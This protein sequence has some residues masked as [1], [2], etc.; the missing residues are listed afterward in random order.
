MLTFRR[1]SALGCVLFQWPCGVE[2]DQEIHFQA[3]AWPEVKSMIDG[4]LPSLKGSSEYQEPDSSYLLL[5]DYRG[6]VRKRWG[7]RV[8][9]DRGPAKFDASNPDLYVPKFLKQYREKEGLKAM[10]QISLLSREPSRA[11][12]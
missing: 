1:L 3:T 5:E 9:Q 2:H 6:P 12:S 4:H 7:V 10:I 11:G 8:E